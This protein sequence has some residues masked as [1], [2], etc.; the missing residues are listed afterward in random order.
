MRQSRRYRGRGSF[1]LPVKDPVDF[2]LPR[3]D[4]P[5]ER[6][7]EDHLLYLLR[8]RVFRSLEQD[9]RFLFLERALDQAFDDRLLRHAST[10]LEAEP[11]LQLVQLPARVVGNPH[12]CDR[13]GESIQSILDILCLLESGPGDITRLPWGL[14]ELPLAQDVL[15]VRVADLV[16]LVS[17]L[18]DRLRRL[19]HAAEVDWRAAH[20]DVARHRLDR[21]LELLDLLRP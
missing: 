3:L 15:E 13:H 17:H 19:E 10:G 4:P 5:I 18:D 8:E 1:A 20:D 9:D 2:L 14:D 11:S 6:G 12:G 21:L 16:K 7:L